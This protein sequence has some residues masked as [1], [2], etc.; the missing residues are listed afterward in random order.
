MLSRGAQS[1]SGEA[2]FTLIEL[3]V[4]IMAGTV[5]LLALFAM[6]DMTMRQTSRTFTMTDATG[7]THY[8]LETIEN[9]LHSACIAD[10]ITPIQAASDN[11]H[12]W[13][14]S[15]YGSTASSANAVTPT[16]VEHE[17]IFDP[18]ANTLRDVVYPETSGSGNNWT[19]S[20]TA[21]SSTIL[22]SNVT[23]P[24][25]AFAFQYFAYQ[26][27][28]SQY[29]DAA[30]NQ[31]E[32]IVDGINYIPGTTIKPTASPLAVP[33]TSSSAQTAAEVLVTLQI[34]ATGGS[35]ENTTNL[36][37]STS[38]SVSDQI[39]LRDTPPA[40]HIGSGTTFTPCA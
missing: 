16:P 6:L 28:G 12:L 40:N 30:G 24:S 33:L 25:G 17:L 2:G 29:T 9:E 13:F 1:P 14:I 34:G 36:N 8:V 11:T 23:V 19:F 39:V 10:G 5:L 38:A 35:N 15:Q 3:L 18:T 21:S 32:M 27:P 20:S 26:N 31:Y 4:A 7:R 22:A 37:S